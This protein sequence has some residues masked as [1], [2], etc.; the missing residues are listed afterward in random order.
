MGRVIGARGVL[1]TDI[2]GATAGSLRGFWA[3]A[4][5]SLTY[6]T[7]GD[8]I[9]LASLVAVPAPWKRPLAGHQHRDHAL[10]TGDIFGE[11]TYVFEAV[12]TSLVDS[13]LDSAA[14]GATVQTG[15]QFN[16]TFSLVTGSTAA[17]YGIDPV[18]N[19]SAISYARLRLD[20][21]AGA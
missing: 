2:S 12:A 5:A 16:L 20:V 1:V 9:D 17:F 11:G 21:S 14:W 6:L 7:A 18:S 13:R 4:N 8:S 19:A 10:S 15:P 3:L